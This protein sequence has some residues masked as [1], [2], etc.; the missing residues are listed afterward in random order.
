MLLKKNFLIALCASL[1]IIIAPLQNAEAQRANAAS[2]VVVVLP[3][4]NVSTAREYNWVGASFADGLADLLDVPGIAIVSNDERELA[5]QRLRLPLTTLPSRATAVKVAREL[6]A[7]MLVVGTYDVTPAQQGDVTGTSLRGTARV[8]RVDEGRLTGEMIEGNWAARQYD[9]G[10]PLPSLQSMQGVL[11]YQILNYTPSA[12]PLTTSRNLMVERAT[13][14]PPRAFESYVKGVMTDDTEKR[15]AYL[16]NALNEYAKANAGATYAEAAFELGVLYFRQADWKRAAESF[17][18]LQKR[19][20]HYTESAFYAALAY[21][22]MNDLQRALGALMPLANDSPLTNIYNNAGAI[23]VQAARNEKSDKAAERTRLLMQAETFLKRAAD[24]TPDDPL[25]RF[26]YAYMLFMAGN[27]AGAAEQL[28]PVIAS[29]PRDG[30][31][32]FLFAK[33]LE[34]DGKTEAAT[35]ADNQARR[36]LPAYAKLQTEWQKSQRVP[37]VPLRLYVEFD[38]SSFLQAMRPQNAPEIA[39][40]DSQNLLIKARD[41]YVA[42]RDDEA[43]P[44]IRRVLMVEPQ[45]AEAYL[46]IGR[47]NS[48]RGELDASISALKTAVFWDPKMIDAHVLLGRIFLQ[49]G[50]RAQASAY[51]RNAIQIDPNNQDALGLLRQVETG[52]R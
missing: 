24:S 9:F 28:R 10:G 42:G 2:D 37:E 43:L 46:L 21:W 52:A 8:I 11:A 19:D 51:A 45:N 44:E 1:I 32:F 5:Y 36:Y 15:S 12:Q 14:I 20:Q 3:F 18:K 38:R 17:V 47:I 27:Y 16:Q 29:N 30:E 23:S 35:E 25:V 7:T 22:R 40:Q 41:L 48:R 50:D 33:A 39:N 13:K 26:N 4:E 31:A 34:R 6:K 49:R